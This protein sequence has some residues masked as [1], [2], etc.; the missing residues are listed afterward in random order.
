MAHATRESH[1]VQ[2]D[3]ITY[4]L[5]Q[6]ALHNVRKHARARQVWLSLLLDQPRVA[7]LRVR[8]D[9]RGFDLE[10]VLQTARAR[11]SLGLTQM[12]ERAERASGTF[13][14]EAAPGKGTT[15]EV[16]LPMREI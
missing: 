8:D 7:I 12:R 3:R 2:V 6:E 15:I 5:T 16:R 9:G 14:I 1:Y 11:G 13:T 4:R 10:H